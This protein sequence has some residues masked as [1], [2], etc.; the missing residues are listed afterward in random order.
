M[1][2]VGGVAF[3]RRDE[4]LWKA[5][6]VALL[7]SVW[8]EEFSSFNNCDRRQAPCES[9]HIIKAWLGAWEVVR[10]N[11]LRLWGDYTLFHC[12]HL[13]YFYFYERSLFPLLIVL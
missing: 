5:H 3:L 8:R 9:T 2:K 7:W 11:I 12:F 6:L 4:I 13:F 10:S 1:W